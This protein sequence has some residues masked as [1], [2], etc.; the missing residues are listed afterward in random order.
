VDF[1][2]DGYDGAG[3]SIS[4]LGILV[5]FGF[6]MVRRWVNGTKRRQMPANAGNLSINSRF[7]VIDKVFC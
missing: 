3:R 7:Y 5:G 2:D 6:L 4:G 1:E